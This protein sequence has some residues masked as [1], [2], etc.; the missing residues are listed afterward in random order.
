MTLRRFRD[1]TLRNTAFGRWLIRTYYHLSPPIAEKLKDAKHML[2]EDFLHEK[3]Q[4]AANWCASYMGNPLLKRVAELFVWKYSYNRNMVYFTLSQGGAISSDGKPYA[5]GQAGKISLAHPIEMEKEEIGAW[6]RY[7]TDKHLKQPFEQVWEP[8]ID[9]ASIHADRYKGCEVPV[10]R[11]INMEKHGISFYDI[12]FHNDIGFNLSACHLDF[13]R[14]PFFRHEFSRNETFTLGKLGIYKVSRQA[15]HEIFLL[16][17]WTISAR[18]LKDDD[19]TVANML[20]TVTAAQI[21]EY[22]TIA[23]ENNCVKFTALLLDYKNKHFA[24][25]AGMDEFRLE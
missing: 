19:V 1:K 8:A 25:F 22:L 4:N 11:F 12:D 2:F 18:I 3:P 15:N 6:Q 21:M 7:F 10:Y 24:E 16:D 13:K 9:P 23:T 5:V 17:K 14:S 20:G